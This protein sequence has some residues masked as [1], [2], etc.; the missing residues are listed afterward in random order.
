MYSKFLPFL[1]ERLCGWSETRTLKRLLICYSSLAF[2]INADCDASS[3]R[4]EG[5]RSGQ[6]AFVEKR[7]PKFRGH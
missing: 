2:V 3:D 1:D 7:A 4:I 5:L 6:T